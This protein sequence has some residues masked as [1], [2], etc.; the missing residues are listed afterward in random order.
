MFLACACLAPGAAGASNKVSS[1]DVTQGK[2]ELEYRGGYDIDHQAGRD[3]REQHKF[4]ANYGILERWRTEVKLVANKADR[5]YDWTAVEWSHRFQLLKGAAGGPKLSV[6]GN[7]IFALEE[8]AA[9]ELAFAVLASYAHHGFTHVMNGT[10]TRAIGGHAK[11]GVQLD[12]GWKTRYDWMPALN[13]GLEIYADLGRHG[14]PDS[15]GAKRPM[16]GPA[17]YGQLAPGL[18]YDIGFLAGMSDSAP[19]GRFK[20]LVTYGF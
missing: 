16:I 7:Y 3:E 8:D 5:R 19:D 11:S 2:I 12:I 20:W 17:L 14:G 4:V 9:D 1:P 18:S 15:S 10:L 6:Q 13:P